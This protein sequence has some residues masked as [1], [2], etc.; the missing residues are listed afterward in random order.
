MRKATHSVN[1]SRKLQTLGLPPRLRNCL[2]RHVPLPTRKGDV[3]NLGARIS[4]RCESEAHC[5]HRPWQAGSMILLTFLMWSRQ[6]RRC[7]RC[8]HKPRRQKKP[9][10]TG[11]TTSHKANN[12]ARE[13][14]LVS[15]RRLRFVQ[16]DVPFLHAVGCRVVH[17]GSWD[18]TRRWFVCCNHRRSPPTWP[19]AS[20]R[21]VNRTIVHV[22]IG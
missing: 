6:K 1:A 14:D 3:R 18:R 10:W 20:S 19:C 11:L 12:P 15:G 13:P 2:Q 21:S 5:T 8:W 4:H 7:G 22:S 9:W 17:I 16:K